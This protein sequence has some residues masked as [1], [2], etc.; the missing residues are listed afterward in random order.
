MNGT[1]RAAVPRR[2]T[3]ARRTP[4]T[5]AVVLFL[6]ALLAGCT[7]VE[8]SSSDEGYSPAKIEEIEGSDVK[9]VTF[10][11]DAAGQVDLQTVQ[12]ARRGGQTVV[13]YA[14]LIYS[15]DGKT[16]VYASPRALT[17]LRT[18]VLVDRIEGD[19]VLLAKGLSPGTTVVTVGAAEVYGAELDMA[20]H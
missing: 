1:G 11:E 5:L 13:P 3:A 2:P 18:P 20:S 14:A 12:A 7:E 9:Q 17:F 10:T 8:A 16:W 19:D 4:L 15:P 6:G